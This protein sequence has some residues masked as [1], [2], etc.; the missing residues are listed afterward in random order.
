MKIPLIS[1]LSLC[2]LATAPAM[3]LGPRA[4]SGDFWPDR[5]QPHF[6]EPPGYDSNVTLHPYTSGLGPCPQGQGKTVCTEAVPPSR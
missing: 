6:Q 1:A 3:A 4:S 5:P 2:L